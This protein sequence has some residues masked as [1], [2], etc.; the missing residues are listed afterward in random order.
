MTTLEKQVKEREEKLEKE[1]GPG[2]K[3]QDDFK[4][5]ANQLRDK[6]KKF[7]AMKDDMK[8]LKNEIALLSR[9]E[10]ILKIRKE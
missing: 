9:T 2:F 10:Q 6:T 8:E 7:K 4:N 3:N 1:R 5:Y